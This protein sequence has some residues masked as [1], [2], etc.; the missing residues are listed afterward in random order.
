MKRFRADPYDVDADGH[1]HRA[2]HRAAIE[3]LE[4]QRRGFPRVERKHAAQH[5]PDNFLDGCAR[6][7]PIHPPR[8][9]RSA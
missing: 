6:T 1:A 8:T 7:L 5:Q 4:R 9:G 3:G 2:A